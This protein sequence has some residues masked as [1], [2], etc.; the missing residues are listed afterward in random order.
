MTFLSSCA[1]KTRLQFYHIEIAHRFGDQ[2]AV[3]P[4]DL[5]G[6]SGF[7]MGKRSANVSLCAVGYLPS[8]TRSQRMDRTDAS[9]RQPRGRCIRYD[10]E[11]RIE[12]ELVNDNGISK[13][14]RAVCSGVGGVVGTPH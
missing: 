6:P 9:P 11:S 12:T 4:P 8:Q 14:V 5:Y 2:R 7:T 1:C 13:H 3:G 10:K